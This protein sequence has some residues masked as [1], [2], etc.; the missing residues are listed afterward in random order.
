VK[1]QTQFHLLIAG[2]LIVP[3][4][5]IL[6]QF[7]YF[8]SLRRQDRIQDEI[9]G[10]EDIALMLGAQEDA[11]DRE[12]LARFLSMEGRYGDIAVFRN[13]FFVLYSTIPE[14]PSRAYGSAERI[15]AL[16]ALKDEP[17]VY[18]LEFLGQRGNHGYVLIRRESPPPR[19]G[20]QL[21]A[22]L[23][24]IFVSALFLFPVI[25]AIVM[26]LVIARSITKS[27]LALENAT[28]RIA[29]GEL[30]LQVGVK[31]SNEITSLTHS[32]NK[33]RNTLREE[34]FR[35]SRF[36]MGVTHDL[37][38]PL[39]LIRAYTEAIEDG[40]AS[41]PAAQVSA[42]EIITAKTDQLEGMINDLLEYVQMNAGEW[43]SQLQEVDIAAFLRGA[44]REFASD[45][46]LLHHEFQSEIAL[47]DNLLVSMNERLV[48][49][50]LENLVNN[51]IRYTPNGSV[52][53]L[54]A[55]LGDSRNG[56]TAQIVVSDNGPGID[57]ADLPH[58]FEMFYRGTSSRREQGMGM[59]L[60]VA[61]W[62]ADSHGWSISARSGRGARFCVVIPL[63]HN[64]PLGLR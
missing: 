41:D 11:D 38:T 30:D 15:F 12:S 43:K 16:A 18:S 39:A 9:A 8:R 47:P 33:M 23:P 63:A 56:S 45:A 6:G 55:S 59:G 13:D 7:L 19:Q 46:E 2:I 58:I 17:Y 24:A 36:I 29:E 40:I 3:I 42:T 50:A 49:R 27:V 28:R 34:E 25:F 44:A 14:F 20:F 61:K 51:A 54:E 52:I 1:I 32:L 21:R 10:Y 22:L 31:G 62:V 64:R 48:L 53:S 37:K 4:I 26:S 57:E 60:A 35:R 5:L